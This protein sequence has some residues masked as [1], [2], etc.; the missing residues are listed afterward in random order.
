MMAVID[1]MTIAAGVE[2][3][4]AAA[5]AVEVRPMKAIVLPRRLFVVNLH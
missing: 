3:V 2:T 4:A 5:A 1:L